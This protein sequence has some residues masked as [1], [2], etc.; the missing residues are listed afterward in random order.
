MIFPVPTGVNPNFHHCGECQGRFRMPWDRERGGPVLLCVADEGHNTYQKKNTG[1][2]MLTDIDGTKTEVDILTQREITELA[3]ITDEPTALEAVTK[4]NALGLFPSKD[5]TPD[6]LAL[7]AHVALLYRL[8]PNMGEIIPYQGKPY[9]TIAGRRRLDAAAGNNVSIRFR[10]LSREEREDYVNVGALHAKDVAGFCVGNNPQTGVTVEGFGRVL[11]NEGM[12]RDG[13]PSEHLPQ[14]VRRIE[15]MQKRAERRMREMM[16]G[17]TPVPEGLRADAVLQEG[18]EI[19]VV[20][21]VGR[22]VEVQPDNDLLPSLGS[23]PEHDVEWD[24]EERFNKTNGF[25]SWNGDRYGCK[26]GS[27]Q[28]PLFKAAWFVARGEIVDAEINTWL[29][30]NFSGKTWSRL[31]PLEMLD[32]VR[33]VK[34]DPSTGEIKAPAA[35][36]T[37]G[38]VPS[39]ADGTDSLPED[40]VPQNTH[41][42]TDGRITSAAV[43]KLLAACGDEVPPLDLQAYVKEQ[44][45]ESHLGN[46][47]GSQYD[48]ILEWINKQ[49]DAKIA[50]VQAQH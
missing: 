28:F 18:D 34:A 16:F 21:S 23:C 45:G 39:W 9:I 43:K 40:D 46:I 44:T 2:R 11:H 10:P 32:A 37:P 14:G 42:N 3:P 5:S 19:N 27:Q 47:L 22:I 29:K 25:H 48:G 1:T 12:G 35:T 15:M 30:A 31:E 41:S 26:F 6:Q 13:K 24:V 17:P 4:A 8:D 50:G 38:E 33:K 36:E 7:L 49:V 20:E